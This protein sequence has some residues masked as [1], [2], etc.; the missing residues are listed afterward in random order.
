MVKDN[1]Y[2]KTTDVIKV[3]QCKNVHYCRVY[4]SQLNMLSAPIRLRLLHILFVT[5][6]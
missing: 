5:S 4:V 6:K 3:F 1:L 2:I